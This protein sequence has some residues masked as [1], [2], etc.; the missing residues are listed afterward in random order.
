MAVIMRASLLRQGAYIVFSC[1]TYVST[2]RAVIR[3][4]WYV[5]YLRSTP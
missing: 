2:L 3:E 5:A 1:R 4:L